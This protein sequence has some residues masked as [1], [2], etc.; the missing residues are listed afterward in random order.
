M[1]PTRITSNSATLIDNIV[2]SADLYKK[3]ECSIIIHDIS[4]HLP[5]IMKISGCLKNDRNEQITYKRNLSTK[6]IEELK[7][8]L[9]SINWFEELKQQNS[10]DGLNL[11]HTKLVS[12]MDDVCPE[13]PTNFS[14]NRNI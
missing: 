11:F 1:R 2:V 8:R 9:N 12:I 13:K 14:T 4:D 6:K 7:R 5:Y 3:Q 10:D